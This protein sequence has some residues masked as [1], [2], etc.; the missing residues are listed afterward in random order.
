MSG[1]S[2]LCSCVFQAEAVKFPFSEKRSPALR[3][4]G[5][6]RSG[7]PLFFSVFKDKVWLD[8]LHV[9]RVRAGLS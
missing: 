7:S 4:G 2:L 6:K 9:A 8:Y 3:F 5:L 1:K